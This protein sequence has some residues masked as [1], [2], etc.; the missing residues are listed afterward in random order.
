MTDA[1]QDY[2]LNQ[3]GPDYDQDKLDEQDRTFICKTLCR[4]CQHFDPHVFDDP[5]EMVGYPGWN[6]CC[7]AAAD[8]FGHECDS[9]E[10]KS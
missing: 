6:P 1:G 10:R 5:E 3:E 8:D 9:Y 4:F 7:S 2:I